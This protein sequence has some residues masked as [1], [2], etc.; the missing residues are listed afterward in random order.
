MVGLSELVR[1]D[2][3]PCVVE[4]ILIHLQVSET[5]PKTNF[6]VISW[7]E[8][9]WEVKLKQRGAMLIIVETACWVH[10]LHGTF[11]YFCIYMTVFRTQ[12]F[13]PFLCHFF[14]GGAF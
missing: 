6:R 1:R 7:G 11:L 9:E 4:V 12:T 13:L 8:G 14:G 5:I 10:G 3:S 2:N